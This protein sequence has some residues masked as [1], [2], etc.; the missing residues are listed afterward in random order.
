MRPRDS[1]LIYQETQSADKSS[2]TIDLDLV[3]P[4]SALSFEFEAQNGTTSNVRNPFPFAITKLEVVD[5]SDVLSSLSFPQAQALQFYKTGKQPELR[6][7]EDAEQLV[8]YG[9]LYPV[10]PVSLRQGVCP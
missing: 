4:V 5:G 3:D 10:R 7:D 9:L 6:E 2:K 1:V 8:G